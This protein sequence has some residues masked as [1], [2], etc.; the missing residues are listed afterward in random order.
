MSM[1]VSLLYEE[2]QNLRCQN[3]FFLGLAFISEFC[4]N[5][6]PIM[7]IPTQSAAACLFVPLQYKAWNTNL[8]YKVIQ[9]NIIKMTFCLHFY[10][11]GHIDTAVSVTDY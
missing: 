10:F 8:S 9:C 3:F 4:T 2:K 1:N 5:F 7:F 11:V 6:K